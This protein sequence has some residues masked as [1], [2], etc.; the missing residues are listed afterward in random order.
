MIEYT[1]PMPGRSGEVCI[2]PWSYQ[3]LG[4][5]LA[6]TGQSAP[7][8]ANWIAV[9]VGVFVPFTVPESF[10]ATKMFWQN[11]T[12]VA[13]NIDVGIFLED[14][15]RVVSAGSTAQATISVI[16][17]VD[18]TDTVLARGRYYMGMTSDTSGITQKVYAL[19]GAAGIY[20]SMGML[21]DTACAPPLSTSAN[22]A[23]FVAYDLAFIPTFG[24][25]G[26]RTA[27]PS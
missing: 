19:A 26:Y 20:Q 13:G 25:Q 11:G 18:I 14:G 15:T 8:S 16:Q 4:V 24:V 6:A 17:T 9:S 22:P 12:A 23:T 2:T 3:S 1:P 5:P 10:T 27:G 7:V 21:K